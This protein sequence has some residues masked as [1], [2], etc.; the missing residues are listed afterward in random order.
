MNLFKKEFFVWLYYKDGKGME[1]YKTTL[2]SYNRFLSS[3]GDA[4]ARAFDKMTDELKEKY[5]QPL[6]ITDIKTFD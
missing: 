4:V 3:R 1:G 5:S 2:C 6:V